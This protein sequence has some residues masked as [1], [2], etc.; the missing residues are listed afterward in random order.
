MLKLTW[1]AYDTCGERLLLER[2]NLS[3]INAFGVYVIWH[4]GPK[5]RIVRV[6]QGVISDRL[7][8]HRSNN[9]ILSYASDG[10]LYVTWAS[11][12]AGLVDGVERYLAER[13]QP[14]V[15]DRFPD[16]APIAVNSPWA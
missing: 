5:P 11:V 1:T 2:V 14:L 3:N 6:G 9:L 15:G 10:P 7:F 8:D 13:Y 4:G 16:V 12:P